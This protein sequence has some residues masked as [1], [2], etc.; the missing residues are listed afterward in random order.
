M[1]VAL[2][3]NARKERLVQQ[4]SKTS[5]SWIRQCEHLV[6][7][8]LSV[9]FS[10]VSAHAILWFYSSMDHVVDTSDPLQPYVKWGLA[11]GFTALGY[12]VSRGLVHRLL[13]RERIRVYL[14]I[15]LLLELVEISANFAQGAVS[16]RAI[17]WLHLFS[18]PIYT[19]L[20][21][22]VYLVMPI[23][24]L[25]TIALA[26]VDMDMDRAKQGYAV[27]G[28]GA[29]PA[30]SA[31]PTA[32]PVA[33]VATAT[34]KQEPRATTPTAGYAAPQ[35]AYPSMVRPIPPATPTAA[36]P[37][38]AGYQQGYAGVVG[39][40]GVRR[41]DA[42]QAAQRERAAAAVPVGDGAAA[43]FLKR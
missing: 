37:G 43:P 1:G 18:G 19:V 30:P 9:L 23:V 33:P 24:P 40:T 10:A 8:V 7:R 28:F 6:L 4:F 41:D 16:I 2:V 3:G 17:D 14:V 20:V 42:A 25:F 31:A 38:A 22:M 32:R 12:F 21:V 26:V 27:R 39:G 29:S 34:P 13:N 5:Q 15:S 35:A 11:L 36:M